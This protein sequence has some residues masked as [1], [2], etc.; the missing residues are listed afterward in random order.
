MCGALLTRILILLE[1]PFVHLIKQ[2]CDKR[3]LINIGALSKVTYGLL[4][5][6]PWTLSGIPDPGMKAQFQV[7][8]SQ[9]VEMLHKISRTSLLSC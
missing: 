7:F 8:L 2:I 1:T 6:A 9:I 3:Q 5:W 4:L